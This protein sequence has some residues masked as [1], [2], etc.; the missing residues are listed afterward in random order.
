LSTRCGTD[1]SLERSGR[2]SV[3]AGD[4]E[5]VVLLVEDELIVAMDLAHL[6]EDHGWQVLGPAASVQ[7]ALQLLKEQ[8][9][10]VAILDINLRDELVTPVAEALMKQGIPFVV[11]TA[12]SNPVEVCGTAV[13]GAPVLRKPT[14][15]EQLLQVL[16]KN[17]DALDTQSQH[18]SARQLTV[19]LKIFPK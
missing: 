6:L 13:R 12:V 18:G 16:E 8:L 19:P 9:P 3:G 7:R 11:S 17:D 10:S 5:K 14:D 1:Q 15:E 2:G 4:L